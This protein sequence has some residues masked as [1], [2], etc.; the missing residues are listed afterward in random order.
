MSIFSAIAR[1]FRLSNPSAANDV[2]PSVGMPA[3][4]QIGSDRYA[5]RIVDVR[6]NGRTVVW[7]GYQGP[8]DADDE[9]TR[10][11]TF[12]RRGDGVY[13]LRGNDY[14]RLRIGDDSPGYLDSSF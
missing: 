4:Y 12:T 3:I 7:E 8:R 1:S 14:G 6:A 11:E 5:G 2:R 10:R 9:P 13:R